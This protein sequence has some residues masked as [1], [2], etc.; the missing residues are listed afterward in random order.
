MNNYEKLEI[1][2]LAF[3]LALK[4]HAVSM[5]LPKFELYEQASQVR[6][7][8]KSIK[9]NIVEAYGRRVYKA[10]FVRFL[11]YAHS[12]CDECISQ[13]KMIN[14]LYFNNTFMTNLIEE[15][16]ILGRKLNKYIQY[17]IKSWNSNSPDTYVP[18][19][20]KPVIRNT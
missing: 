2:Q 12:S 4:V 6:R 14:Q 7:S 16:N 11:I 8:S 9:D 17:V 5:D 15:Y 19:N 10:E 20:P 18:R 1:Y 3:E 13:L